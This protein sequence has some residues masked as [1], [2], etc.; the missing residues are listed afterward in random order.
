MAFINILEASYMDNQ[1][2]PSQKPMKYCFRC[3]SLLDANGVCPN[4]GQLCVSQSNNEQPEQPEVKQPQIEIVKQQSDSQQ[5]E[6]QYGQSGSQQQGYQYGKSEFP[7]QGYDNGQPYFQQQGYNYAQ[8]N[9]QQ[10]G[11]PQPVPK[12]PAGPN[13]FTFTFEYLKAFFSDNPATV[14]DRA[15]TDKHHVWSIL[16]SASVLLIT[17]GIFC[18][19]RNSI[20]KIY[21]MINEMVS[22]FVSGIP[23][24]GNSLSSSVGES[25]GIDS[26]LSD[27][28]VKL[29][30]YSLLVVI[31]F[32]FASAG[33]NTLF[34][35]IQKKK[36]S[37]IQNMNIL[38]A[39]MLPLAVCGASAMIMSFIY[40][41]IPL[42][43]FTIGIM[44]K[45]IML[46][47][48]LKKV[49]AFEKN[50]LWYVFGLIAVNVVS[51]ALIAYILGKIMF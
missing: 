12:A 35:Y 34:F 50:P 8:P 11:Y 22:N 32:F 40:L 42:F 48:G 28:K 27:L 29:F 46:Y 44:F 20:N 17:L 9:L 14:L 6:Y 51:F 10:Q 15:A 37:Y 36:V 41:P 43:L 23:F 3:G 30:I 26:Q 2:K 1:N 45:Y 4:C 19:M 7:Q 21:D 13:I 25:L 16:G 18:V 49:A 47:E 5:Q 31:A 38:S 24:L 39:A 33:L